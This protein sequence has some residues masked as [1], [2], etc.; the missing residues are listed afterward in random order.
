[1]QKCFKNLISAGQNVFACDE[2]VRTVNS[3]S[4]AIFAAVSNSVHV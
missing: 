2:Y 4:D 1:M 3:A